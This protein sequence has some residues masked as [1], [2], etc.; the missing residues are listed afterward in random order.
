MLGTYTV[1]FMKDLQGENMVGRK[2]EA[3]RLLQDSDSLRILLPPSVNCDSLLF[4]PTPRP[5]N[6][7]LPTCCIPLKWQIAEI[8]EGRR[9]KA[10]IRFQREKRWDKKGK[11][12][13][14][15]KTQE[16]PKKEKDC[17]RKQPFCLWGYIFLHRKCIL[18]LDDKIACNLVTWEKGTCSIVPKPLRKTWPAEAFYFFSC[19]W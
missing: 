8:R 6:N 19:S 12:K 9:R 4:H 1:A 18:D 10:E 17:V 2:R 5:L 7:S 15:M 14:K 3:P 16:W 13:I 11:S